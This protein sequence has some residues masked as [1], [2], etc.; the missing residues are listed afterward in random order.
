MTHGK[1]A[2]RQEVAGDAG[3]ENTAVTHH[4]VTQTWIF[5]LQSLAELA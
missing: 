2:C 1:Q 3:A 4:Y 5:G